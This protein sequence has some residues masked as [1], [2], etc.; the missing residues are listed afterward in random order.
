M[1]LGGFAPCPLPLGGTAV[2]GLTAEQH[3]R[4]A[5]DL[6]AAVLGAP[7]AIYFQDRYGMPA[8]LKEYYLGQHGVAPAAI[9]LVSSGGIGITNFIWQPS[10]SDEYD[11]VYPTNIRHAIATHVWTAASAAPAWCS[12]EITAYNALSVYTTDNAA[13]FVAANFV[14][15]VW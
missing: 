2:D 3:A 6:K 4:I 8:T 12:V 15:A 10:Y 11:N 1:A 14:L 7:F 9:P 13:A 5:A